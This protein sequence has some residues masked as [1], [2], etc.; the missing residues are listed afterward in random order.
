MS[1]PMSSLEIEDVLASIRRLV[2]DDLRPA[3][4]RPNPV[5]K[6]L[7]TPALRVVVPAGVVDATDAPLDRAPDAV[8]TTLRDDWVPDRSTLSAV[9]DEDA[10]HLDFATLSTGATNRPP[11]ARTAM[12]SAAEA[13]HAQS[14]EFVL[15]YSDTGSVMLRGDAPAPVPPRDHGAVFAVLN[16]ANPAVALPPVQV[17]L[18]AEGGAPVED[19]ANWSTVD[20]D[21]APHAADTVQAPPASAEIL[22]DDDTQDGPLIL[23]FVSARRTGGGDV[24]TLRSPVLLKI[25]ARQGA[26]AQEGPPDTLVLQR[27]PKMKP[28]HVAARAA[29]AAARKDTGA[30]AGAAA[31]EAADLAAATRYVGQEMSDATPAETALEAVL[32][33][34]GP[35]QPML[36]DDPD[37]AIAADV[38][39]D[40]HG[41]SASA[42]AAEDIDAGAAQDA[43]APGKDAG[44]DAPAAKAA[45][46]PAK[47]DA[48]GGDAP[49][50]SVQGTRL[51]TPSKLAEAAFTRWPG[52]AQPDP[53]ESAAAALAPPEPAAEPIPQAAASRR[54][55]KAA[56]QDLGWADRAEAEIHRQL[57]AELGPSV[58]G[59]VAAPASGLGLQLSEAALR[60]LVRDMIREELTGKLGERITQNVRKLVQMELQKTMALNVAEFRSQR[61]DPD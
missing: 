55:P 14:D 26:A 35:G 15:S 47:N 43:T 7:L 33:Q 46:V 40:L 50:V 41:H 36:A 12:Q 53:G 18:D 31:A 17:L 16:K 51:R 42:I 8:P 10:D 4:N 3:A 5:G 21:D 38:G 56:V 13:F 24:L 1:E 60:D 29:A 32:D 27:K 54:K 57:A 28:K 22:P 37:M 52:W 11:V 23:P 20:W 2:S 6:L 61:R 19:E 59:E 48:P 9:T 30:D 58:L 49:S 34:A 39:P 25:D 44:D 45:D